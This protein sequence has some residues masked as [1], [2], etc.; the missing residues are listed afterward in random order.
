MERVPMNQD[1]NIQ[2]LM[3]FGLT[4]LQASIYLN[5]AKLGKADVKTLAKA[6]NVARQDIYRIMPTL[7]KLGLTE[8]IIAKPTMYKTTP[9]K[10]GLLILFQNRKKEYAELQKKA[11]L[12][13]NNFQTNTAKIA[14]Q[15]EDTQFIITSEITRF[16]K[17]HK[18]LA[19]K[20][21][22]SIDS[23]IPLNSSRSKLHESLSDLNESIRRGV[24]IRVITKQVEKKNL[25]RELQIL[26]KNP[27]CELKYSAQPPNFGMYIFDDK[28][29]TI[30]TTKDGLPS[31]WS[32]NPNVVEIASS[33]FNEMWSKK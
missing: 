28:E 11:T 30:A 2:T 17:R 7:Q 31:L 15:E 23:I 12:L 26:E 29:V 25:P 20:A 8:K 33:Y 10:E 21:Q 24:K 27:L 16:L 1:E 5:L 6:S 13:I 14:P 22:T 9:I 18:S 4:F 19:Q 32:N 3:G